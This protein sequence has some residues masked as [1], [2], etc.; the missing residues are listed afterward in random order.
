[1]AFFSFQR[2][3]MNLPAFMLRVKVQLLVHTRD[4][5]M[6]TCA[7]TCCLTECQ[8]LITFHFRQAGLCEELVKFSSMYGI[9]IVMYTWNGGLDYSNMSHLYVQFSEQNKRTALLLLA[10]DH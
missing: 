6:F 10:I 5:E 1:M 8:I 7:C 2:Y 3:G 4:S 9:L